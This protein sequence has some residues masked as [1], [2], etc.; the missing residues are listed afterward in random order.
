MAGGWLP[1]LALL[2]HDATFPCSFSNRSLVFV[3]WE[4]LG[5][6]GAHK[7]VLAQHHT[8]WLGS[9]PW[10]IR[11][12]QASFQ[13][14]SQ[15]RWPRGL[16]ATPLRPLFNAVSHSCSHSPS[17]LVLLHRP[18]QSCQGAQAE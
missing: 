12:N 14:G 18:L 16:L 10:S 7:T 11:T 13:I 9:R 1:G 17:P 15:V 6:R 2:Q 5:F 8:S 3:S 4:V